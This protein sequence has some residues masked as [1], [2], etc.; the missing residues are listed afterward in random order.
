MTKTDETVIK[1]D[2]TIPSVALEKESDNDNQ[3]KALI[4]EYRA[5]HP[6]CKTGAE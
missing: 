6:L 3:T 1:N 5:H 2:L 4:K